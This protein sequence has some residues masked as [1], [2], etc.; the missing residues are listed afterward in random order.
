MTKKQLAKKLIA[1][2]KYLARPLPPKKSL[3]AT[4]GS[5]LA[6]STKWRLPNAMDI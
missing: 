5:W 3:E 1:I 2:K 4:H 6:F